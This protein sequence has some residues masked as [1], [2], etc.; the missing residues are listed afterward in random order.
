MSFFATTLLAPASAPTVD[1]VDDRIWSVLALATLAL[2]AGV[3]VSSALVVACAV[4]PETTTNFG[5]PSVN[6]NNT[7]GMT[8]AL[9]G[10]VR[11]RRRRGRRWVI[12]AIVS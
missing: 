7:A 11:R 5:P 4:W 1:F 10:A 3:S 8:H 2:F 9:A 6:N 12:V